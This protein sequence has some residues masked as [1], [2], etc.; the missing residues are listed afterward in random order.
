MKTLTLIILVLSI[1]ILVSA[2]MPSQQYVLWKVWSDDSTSLK[3]L[4]TGNYVFS[5][6]DTVVLEGSDTDTLSFDVPNCRGYFTL[7][8]IPDTANFPVGGTSHDHLIGD[9]DS[10]SISYNIGLDS[11]IKAAN[12]A[13]QLTYIKNFDWDA[14]GAYYESIEPPLSEYFEFYISHTGDADTSAVIIEIQWQ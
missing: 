1:P 4:G 13:I 6:R 2:Q 12:P 8:F 7:W 5:D 3:T 14:E 9:T 11:N 10:T